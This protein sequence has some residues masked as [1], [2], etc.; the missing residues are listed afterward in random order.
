MKK[1]AVSL[2]T[3]IVLAGAGAYSAAA[4]GSHEVKSGDTLWGISQEHNTSVDE[5]KDI[6]NLDSN[7]I[8]PGDSIKLSGS[9]NT[10]GTY[11]VQSGDTLWGISQE[12]GVQV[13]Q[14]KQWNDLQSDL[15]LVG[16]ELALDGQY[17]AETANQSTSNNEATESSQS[18]QA[19][20]ESA[21][22]SESNVEQASQEVAGETFTVSATAYTA[23]CAGCSGITA[24]GTNL[25]ENPNA[26]VIAVDPNV[27]PLG[28]KVYVEGYGE[29]I[30]ADTGGA[31][32]GN[33]IDLH[34]PTKAEAFDWGVRNVEI[35][36]L[37]EQ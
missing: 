22:A 10:E 15:I 14:L 13:N 35:T 21:S 31:I 5:I 36:I 6:N 25:N 12:Q 24:N 1:V 9:T 26:K 37:D 3:G 34:V 29:A 11:K 23:D 30:A 20:D 28:T 4:D 27:I 19:A 33:K 2:A 8:L 32:K 18:E 17:T 16:Q 7:L